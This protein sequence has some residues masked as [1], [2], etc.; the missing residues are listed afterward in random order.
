[1]EV[2]KAVI[3]EKIR[4][5]ASGSLQTQKS[6]HQL[7]PAAE[8]GKTKVDFYQTNKWLIGYKGEEGKYIVHKHAVPPPLEKAFIRSAERNPVTDEYGYD[9]NQF[10]VDEILD[11]ENHNMENARVEI[12]SKALR[13][14]KME[15]VIAGVEFHDNEF[16]VRLVH[17]PKSG[18]YPFSKE[19]LL[20]AVVSAKWRLEM[21]CMPE[22]GDSEGEPS[23]P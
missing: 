14:Q 10:I 20:K 3:G 21:Y 9:H 13:S 15:S 6:Q 18:V 5:S 1:M 22:T 17:T 8:A 23:K 4:L 11:H 7:D 19:D 16:V 12:T 2:K